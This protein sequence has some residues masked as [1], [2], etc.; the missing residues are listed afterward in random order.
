M[1]TVQN[2][3]E[4]VGW[5]RQAS[6]ERHPY[7]STLPHALPKAPAHTVETKCKQKSHKIA[8]SNAAARGEP[9]VLRTVHLCV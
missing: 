9:F 5:L 7:K 2:G 1:E 4:K 3:T 8:D 6:T